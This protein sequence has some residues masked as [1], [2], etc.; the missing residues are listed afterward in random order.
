MTEFQEETIW[1]H[2]KE[3]RELLQEIKS[4]I[5]ETEKNLGAGILLQQGHSAEQIACSYA[6]NC[7]YIEALEYVKSKI[8][9][10]E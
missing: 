1:K 3:T 8:S 10:E 6:M 9:S 4:K 7:G 5:K 2:L